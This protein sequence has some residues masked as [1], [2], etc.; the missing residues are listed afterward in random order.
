MLKI[1]KETY[2]ERIKRKYGDSFK[3]NADPNGV[4]GTWVDD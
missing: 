1:E 3:V 4:L 2:Q